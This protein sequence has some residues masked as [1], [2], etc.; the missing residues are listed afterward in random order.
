MGYAKLHGLWN[1]YNIATETTHWEIHGHCLATMTPHTKRPAR[2][3]PSTIPTDRLQINKS[4]DAQ[5][6]R[7]TNVPITALKL[8]IFRVKSNPISLLSG[9]WPIESNTQTHNHAHTHTHTQ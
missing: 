6:H 4:C 7:P 2:R 8:P 9:T 3:P 5:H 1:T